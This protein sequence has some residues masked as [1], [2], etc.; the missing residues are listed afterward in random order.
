LDVEGKPRLDAGTTEAEARMHDVLVQMQ[1]LA[2]PQPQPA[3]LSLR[4]AVILERLT[5]L[6]RGEHA[7][8][9]LLDRLL[10]KQPSGQRFLV[11]GRG[12]KVAHRSAQLVGLG[13]RGLLEP[14]RR[15]ADELLEVEQTDAGGLEK[16]EHAALSHQRQQMAAERQAIEARQCP[17]D[18]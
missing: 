5:R 8:Q 10:T 12:L 14:F 15:I 18:Q 16:E 2:R 11:D 7:D 1:A 9:A 17:R 13:E 4:R 6:E 3:L